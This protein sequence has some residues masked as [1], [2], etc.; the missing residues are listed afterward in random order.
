MA[1]AKTVYFCQSCGMES[2]K[3]MGQC[4]SC[5]EWNTFAEE[6]VPTGKGSRSASRRQIQSKVTKLNEIEAAEEERI[7][8][9]IAELD[10]VLGGGIVPGSMTLVGGDPGIGKSTLLLQVCQK[11]TEQNRSI[12]YV[13]GE[14]S[15][16][17][18]KIRA[19]RIGKIGDALS[20]LCETNL[21]VIGEIIKK[22]RP[23]IVVI[24]SIQ[25]MYHEAISSAPGSVSQVRESTGSLLMLAKGLG[26]AFFIIGHETKEGVVAGPRVLEQMVDTV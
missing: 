20:L 14:E 26:I 4:S 6:E 16:R 3:W 11:L 18:I 2:A 7:F 8:T 1:K 17:Q 10:R 24:D 5:G 21:D 12:L 23:Q 25:T 22:E 19:A 15:L 13:S 9:G